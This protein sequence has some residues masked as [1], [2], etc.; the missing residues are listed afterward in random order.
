MLCIRG[1]DRDITQ[2]SEVH[3]SELQD[4]SVLLNGAAGTNSLSDIRGWGWGFPFEKKTK[5]NKTVQFLCPTAGWKA[6][7]PLLSQTVILRGSL[8]LWLR[9][10][11]SL[12]AFVEIVF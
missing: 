5:Q 6:V 9:S 3:V 7:H 8:H 11:C 2:K 12:R 1:I 4:V 10:A